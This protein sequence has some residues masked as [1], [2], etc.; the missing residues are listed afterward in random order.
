MNKRF[1]HIIK[2]TLVL[3]LF[4]SLLSGC[5]PASAVQQNYPLES[6]NGS[7][8]NTSYV[9]RAADMTVPE[10]ANEL[11]EERTPEEVS[12]QDT[13]RMFLVYSD[14][15]Y[16]LQQDPEA[17]EDTLIEVDSKQYVQQNYS[18]SFL[19]GYI[20]ASI[21]SSIFDTFKGTGNYRGY[22]T[23]KTYKPSQGS[24]RTPTDSDKSMAPPLT[25]KKSG[26]I[27]RRGLGDTSDSNKST[28][29]NVLERDKSSSSSTSK[30]KIE[31]GKSGGSSIFSSPKKSSRPKTKIG[32]G[33]I[34]R[35]R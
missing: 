5:G 26:S 9:Y 4:I 18:S 15:L 11:M 13:E 10:V 28:S 17:P 3:S 16:H 7:G 6:V 2:I 30:G 14:E 12:P 23:Q 29:G 24:Y 19:Q 35:R 33:R 25:T 22:T 27:I 31:R 34:S 20:T 8:N 32:S 21:L 1:F